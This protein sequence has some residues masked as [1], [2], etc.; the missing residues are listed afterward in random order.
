MYGVRRNLSISIIHIISLINFL[1]LSFFVCGMLY[2]HVYNMDICE[3]HSKYRTLVLIQYMYNW[4][5]A[6]T[7]VLQLK[8]ILL[9]SILSCFCLFYLR[10][11]Y[12]VLFVLCRLKRI[13]LLNAYC[14]VRWK[15]GRLKEI[16]QWR[17]D[18]KLG[19]KFYMNGYEQINL[20]QCTCICT[21]NLYVHVTVYNVQMY[22]HVWPD[23]C[24]TCS[25]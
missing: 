12:T 20:L 25:V 14:L 17:V 10:N 16:K 4:I 19:R 11:M 2:T 22:L 5:D 3:K 15:S 6:P 1:H 18:L 7:I 21:V 24:L 23:W 9:I 13:T 8:K